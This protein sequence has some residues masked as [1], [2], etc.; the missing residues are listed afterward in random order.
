MSWKKS[1]DMC[2]AEIKGDAAK[3][4]AVSAEYEDLYG[5]ISRDDAMDACDECFTRIREAIK[6]CRERGR[7]ER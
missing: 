4:V 2:G 3:V 1:C 7:H 6:E 5:R